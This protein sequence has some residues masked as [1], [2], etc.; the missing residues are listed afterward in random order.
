MS[1]TAVK[2]SDIQK[3][4]MTFPS[5]SDLLPW[6]EFSD[7]H[8]IMLLEDKRSV[9][10]ALEIKDIPTE[11]Q[12]ED[13]IE[14]LHLKVAKLFSTVVPLEEENPWVIQ[15]FI[16]DD[17]TL[18][19]LYRRLEE[20][21]TEKGLIEDA[22]SKHYLKL[23]KSHFDLMCEEEGILNDPMSGLAFRGRTKRIRLVV[24]RRFDEKTKEHPQDIVRELKE[25][26]S[27]LESRLKQAGLR[28]RIL[29][30]AQLYD[31]L[32]RWFNPRPELS[33]GNTNELLKKFPYPQTNKKPFG[34]SFCQNVFFGPV[35]SDQESGCWKFD[36]LYHKT[37][38]FKDLQN[39]IE[40]G[41]ISRE[42][43]FGNGQSK[44]ALM[45]KFPPGTI[46]T[47]QVIFESKNTVKNHLEKLEKAAVGK[48]LSIQE[49]LNNIERA[50]YEI[51]EKGNMLFRCVEAIYFR[52]DSIEQM[53]VNE[54]EIRSLL[55]DSG[56]D[57]VNTKEEL[58]PLDNYIRFLPFN[59]NYHF[60]KKNTFRST[61]KYADDIMR[62]LPIY[63]RSK[64]DDTNPLFI[65]FNRGGEAFI[66]DHLD[67]NFKMSNSHMAIMGTTGSGKSVTLNNLLL[68][69]SAVHNPHII[70]LEVGGS[71]DLTTKYL[72]NFGRST[73]TIK[74]QRQ[75]P[76]QINPYS[77]AYE[78]L[79]TIEREESLAKKQEINKQ[80]SEQQIQD[81]IIE[82]RSTKIV[83]DISGISE[84]ASI[85]ELNANE[86]RDILN[87][88]L[89][90]TRT[91]ITRGDK[92]EEENINLTDMTLISKALIH[93]M[94]TCKKAKVEQMLL[95]HVCQ[96]FFD[97]ATLEEN[98][99]LSSRLKE[100]GLRLEY[101]VQDSVRSS[102]I[103]HPSNPLEEYDLLHIDFG[104]LQSASYVDL[105]NV[106]CISLLS[107]I[108]AL[109]EKNKATGRPTILILDEAHVFFKSEMV[110][111]FVT[112][113]AKVAR[114]IG[115]WI[116]PC[117]QN[118]NDLSGKE[119]RKVL[120]MMETWLILSLDKE[121][122]GHLEQFKPLTDE[123]RSLVMDVR[124]Y[125]GIYSEAVLLG[126]RYSGLYRNIP[127]RIALALAMT[128]QDERTQRK[129]LQ[130]R[131]GITEMEAVEHIA[132][133]LEK[134][135]SKKSSGDYFYD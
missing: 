33:G 17:V 39:P 122:V 84:Q 119:S 112:L 105:L 51:D 69:F 93:S 58:Y 99:Q 10:M 78:A 64:G 110:A 127:P 95:Q 29:N 79:K 13:V 50:H 32:I 131:L 108:L 81:D 125:P 133:K 15:F 96:S 90:A 117:T 54:R 34:W 22:F 18:D 130:D 42:R 9:G 123:M 135:A 129:E 101:Y 115:L 116:I 23:M 16:Q 55:A 71:F 104:F 43:S 77:E 59:F 48:S 37:M 88:M 66:F 128:E 86:D 41:V 5:F 132:K 97:L 21:I 82:M 1:K 6:V 87:E 35:E 8:N 20:Y 4:Y 98:V 67:K 3:Q 62:L 14:A 63:G 73:K 7:E 113:M 106:V 38:V 83:K 65:N 72:G 114:K 92:K 60:D 107:K 70:V 49:I 103:N 102:F 36:D 75:A 68:S 121:E 28:V 57:V 47:I 24:Y 19:P 109:A 27:N 30:G 118:I 31:W 80:A 91:M 76:I 124:K 56:L 120:S 53:N 52:A 11:A 94:K 45:D 111:A 100:F 12:K 26:I 2:K 40:I 134:K 61:Y 85:D 46:Y 44:Y 25:N 126:K 89:L 74:F